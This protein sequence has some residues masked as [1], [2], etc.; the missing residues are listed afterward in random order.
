[1]N[2]QLKN[3]LTDWLPPALLRYAT[4]FFYGWKGNYPTW[5][6]AS[7]KSKGYDAPSILEKVTSAALKVKKGEAAFERDSVLFNQPDYAFPLLA[8]LF[9]V[10][11]EKKRLQVLDYGGSLGS[12]YF[13][14]KKLFT[15]VPSVQWHVVE[16]KNFATAGKTF[17]ENETLHF[18]TSVLQSVSK[19]MAD[20]ALFGSSLQYLEFPLS[21]I[22]EIVN[23]GIPY[24]LIDR[25][26]LMMTK[27]TRITVQHVHPSIYNASYPC[28]LFNI[29][30]LQDHLFKN[31]ELIH[32]WKH[33]DRINI[34]DAA[35]FGFF[36]KRK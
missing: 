8:S 23:A 36:L 17:F 2:P 26:P 27:P 12:L 20:V 34:S 6:A 25:T 33:H 31:F 21:V 11:F 18:F 1:M 14:H 16:Q 15:S 24:L 32:Q 19:E 7:A 5:E 3:F 35:F 4:G 28:R 29:K 9:Y 30:E 13:Q 22:D 10:A